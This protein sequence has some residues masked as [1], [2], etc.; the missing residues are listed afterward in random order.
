LPTTKLIRAKRQDGRPVFDFTD[1][2][3]LS[4]CLE[5]KRNIQ[6]LLQNAK[7]LEEL[8]L[9]VE[10]RQD[11]VGLHD[12]I[13]TSARTLKVL[14][15]TV[16]IYDSVT[17]P[18]AGLYKCLEAMAGRNVLEALSFE[19][20]VDD[21][22]TEDSIGSAVQNVEKILVKPGW[23]VLRQ[24]SFKVSIDRWGDSTELYEALQSLPDKYLS[25]I[26]KVETITFKYS[27]DI[28]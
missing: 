17:L 1:L 23:S 10:Y 22:E 8:H 2:R 6:Y 28:L 25:H 16:S 19:L 11:L 21:F 5:D 15:L 9:S 18:L 4:I 3:R 7:L 12:I 14:D 26:S 20:R 24:A 13:S 27:V